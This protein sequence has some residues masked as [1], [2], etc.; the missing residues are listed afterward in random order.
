VKLAEVIVA[1]PAA[2]DVAIAGDD[3]SIASATAYLPAMR[4]R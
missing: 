2:V 1:V 3:A 4:W